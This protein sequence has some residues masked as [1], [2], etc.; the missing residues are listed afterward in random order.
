MAVQEALHLLRES[1][2]ETA[3]I[4]VSVTARP[5]QTP[6][7]LQ[8]GQRVEDGAGGGVSLPGPAPPE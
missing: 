1:P 5:G 2:A 3:C 4:R 8:H 7:L 6:Q